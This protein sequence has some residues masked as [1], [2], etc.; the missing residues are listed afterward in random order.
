MDKSILIVD[1]NL[2]MLE[3]LND[4]LSEEGY[5]ITTAESVA[6]ATTTLRVK[7]YNLVLVDLK[8]TD[9]TGLDLL[10]EIKRIDAETMVIVFTAYASLETA[11]AT[12]NEGAAGYL[13][14]P[15]NMD[16]VKITI[17]KAL[18]VQ[19]L[20]FENKNLLAQLKEASFKDIKTGLY[21]YRYLMERLDVE[22]KRGKRYLLPLSVIMLDIDYF[23]SV[24]EVYGHQYGD[25]ILNEFSRFLKQSVRGTDVVARYGGEEFVILMSDTDKGGAV[26]FGGRL[27]ERLKEYI[28]DRNDKRLKLKASMGV[29]SFPED[30]F[31]KPVG[32]LNAADKAL[33][34]AK[35]KGGNRLSVFQKVSR[36]EVKDI[37]KAGG[38]ENIKKLNEKIS[39]IEHRAN[40]ILL[41]SIYAF[42]KAVETKDYYTGKH[43]ENMVWLAAEI[44]KR[45]RLAPK[46]IDSVQH[47]AILH[48]LGKI[49]IPDKILHKR[50]PLTKREYER[51]KKHP[52]IGAEIIRPI[53]FLHEAV[54][55][56]L[57]HHERFDGKGYLSRLKG[58]D[59]PLGARIIA[60]ADAYQ[61]LISD[62]PYRKAL[63]KAEAI[64][65]IRE[66]SGTHFD[67]GIVNIFLQIVKP[68]G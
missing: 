13:Q 46:D 62:R 31:D 51:L 44:A 33:A 42:A 22:F 14:K 9:G 18:G 63:S 41:E 21:N 26:R 16:E 10:K 30:E 50:K 67:P 20:A 27:S 7:S 49:G 36:K 66:G 56:V 55:M 15:L 43:S 57:Y 53:H 12:M 29:A 8:L 4:I 65:I 2:E 45:L 34:E 28:F 19:E 40:Q 37:V 17:K 24:N 23:K 38:R 3:T 35:E 61:A 5:N 25:V 64:K 60:I 47:A 6:S 1:D 54:S 68:K 32:L 59:I 48:D 58:K 39:T 11:I 52:Q